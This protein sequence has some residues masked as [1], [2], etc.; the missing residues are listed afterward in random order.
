MGTGMRTA[1]VSETEGKA[2]GES[3]VILP[4]RV[5]QSLYIRFKEGEPCRYVIVG[6][7]DHVQQYPASTKITR[8]VVVRNKEK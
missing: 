4:Y 5:G 6:I 2:L 7:S 1:I 3:D 8:I